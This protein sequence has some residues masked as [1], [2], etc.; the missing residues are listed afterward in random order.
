MSSNCA[1]NGRQVDVT[2]VAGVATL[3]G[4]FGN[5]LLPFGHAKFTAFSTD[6]NGP[7]VSYSLTQDAGGRFTIDPVT[8]IVTVANGGLLDFEAATSHTITVEASDGAAGTASQ[9]FTIAVTNVTAVISGTIFVDTDGNGLFDGGTE[10]AI[11]AAIVELFDSDGNLLATDETLGGVYSFN[12]NDEFGTYH[13]RK[14]QPSDVIN[15]AAILGDANGNAVTGETADG[16]VLS[17]NEMQ[18]T[19]AGFN[20]TDYDFTEIGQTIQAG[21]TA[22]I[23]FWQN[24][25]GQSLI[26]QGGQALAIWLSANFGNIFGNTFSNGS[27]GDDAAEVASSYKNVFFNKK[28]QGTSKVDAQFMATALATFFTSSHLSGGT[29]A[30]SYGFNVTTSGISTK[31]VNVGVNGAAFGVAN[32]KTMSI[33]SLL[34]ATNHL[35]GADSD[36]DGSED[37]SLVYDTNGDGILSATERALRTMANNVYA[38]INEGGGI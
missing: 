15:G 35:T 18:L 36:L 38:A 13:I 29:R 14:V 12:V 34:L 3:W 30:A 16:T 26:K 4:R 21:D 37:Y 28:L 33:M 8:G 22:G 1:T 27:G 20:A 17:S 11:D 23:G 32:Y 9:S 19:L 6:P 2:V 24:K 10:S 31:V 25:N 7:A 5:D